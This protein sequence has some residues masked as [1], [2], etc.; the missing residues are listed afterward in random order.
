M[1]QKI[2]IVFLFLSMISFFGFSQDSSSDN[3]SNLKSTYSSIRF[4]YGH[5]YVFPTNDFLTTLNENQAPITQQRNL[6]GEFLLQ[7]TGKKD[8]HQKFRFPK[9]GIG[10]QKS[11][12]PQTAEIGSPIAIYSLIESPIHRW[13]NGQIDWGFH[14]GIN[15]NWN[16]YN[17]K[18]NP[19]NVI[20]GSWAT[21]HAHLALIYHQDLGS[22]FGLKASIGVTH[23][24]NGNI[25]MPNYGIN[26]FDPRIGITYNL[27]KVKPILESHILEPFVPHNEISLTSS[28]GS[29]QLDV[30]ASSEEIQEEFEGQNFFVYNFIL[31]YQRQVSPL[32]RVGG[33]VDFTVDESD[34]ANGFVQGDSNALYPA[35][36]NQQTKFAIVLSYEL[37]LDKLSLILQPG[38]YFYRTTHDPRPFFYQRIGVRYNLID[39]LYAGASLRAVNFG[40]ADWSEFSIGYKLNF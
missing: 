23:A 27:Y 32:S 2:K 29:K 11:W 24:S 17:K 21:I 6:T 16:P 20:I 3:A 10:I 8:W 38:F 33:G 28:F 18:T 37:C 39:G 13:K 34:N 12:Y 19:N 9:V 7:T 15:L 14:F 30:T 35:P 4:S 26:I 36:Y 5:G 1:C 40:Q 25:K 22:R 31:L